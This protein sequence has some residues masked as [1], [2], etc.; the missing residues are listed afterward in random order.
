M[1]SKLAGYVGAVLAGGLFIFLWLKSGGKLQKA[2]RTASLSDSAVTKALEDN[3][4]PVEIYEE[5]RDEIVDATA[6]PNASE[7]V[8]RWNERAK[9]NREKRGLPGSSGG[10]VPGDD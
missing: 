4:K 10:G 2:Q 6:N 8:R 9:A 1:W 5:V 7:L 3:S